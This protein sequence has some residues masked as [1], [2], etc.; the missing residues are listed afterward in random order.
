MSITVALTIPEIHNVA[1]KG[2]FRR[3]VD[4]AI[5]LWVKMVQLIKNDWSFRIFVEAYLSK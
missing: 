1:C 3:R 5:W 4:A 2:H